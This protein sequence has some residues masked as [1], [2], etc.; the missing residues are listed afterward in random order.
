[1]VS[2]TSPSV[3]PSRWPTDP[4]VPVA[5]RASTWLTVDRRLRIA[6]FM[7]V[8]LFIFLPAAFAALGL[9]AHVVFWPGPAYI[10][11]VRWATPVA[12]WEIGGAT[13]GFLSAAVFNFV[14]VT[15]RH[16]VLALALPQFV[17]SFKPLGTSR[18]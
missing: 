16:H 7:R 2:V 5:Q 14:S 15:R 1:M 18:S 9:M 4:L 13:V 12:I 6:L 11:S 17:E 8:A 10:R 3:R